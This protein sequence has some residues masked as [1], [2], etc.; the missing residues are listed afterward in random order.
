MFQEFCF[1]KT[2][3][4]KFNLHEARLRQPHRK[5]MHSTMVQLHLKN[6]VKFFYFM[7]K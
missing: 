4:Q 5:R 3:A 1:E 6:E 7:L 2:L